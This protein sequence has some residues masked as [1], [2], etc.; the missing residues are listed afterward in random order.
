MAIID[1][2]LNDLQKLKDQKQKEQKENAKKQKM[3]EIQNLSAQ[4]ISAL[5]LCIDDE[6]QIQNA[7]SIKEQINLKIEELSALNEVTNV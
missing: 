3:Q 7:V 5:E 4:Y 6:T 2:V 1:D